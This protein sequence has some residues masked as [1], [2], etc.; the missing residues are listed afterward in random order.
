MSFKAGVDKQGLRLM[1]VGMPGT[2]SLGSVLTGLGVT[3]AE[4]LGDM[5]TATATT[6]VYVP[7]VA[8]STGIRSMGGMLFVAGFMHEVSLTIHLASAYVQVQQHASFLGFPRL[9]ACIALD[10]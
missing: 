3:G 5:L 8:G 1:S 10:M 7:S 2:L 6:V 4:S 9:A